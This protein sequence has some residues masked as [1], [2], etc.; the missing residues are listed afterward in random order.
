MIPYFDKGVP[1]TIAKWDMSWLCAN[2]PGGACEDLPRRVA[3]AR[4]REYNT[5]RIE[6]YP[7]QLPDAKTVFKKNCDP[8]AELPAWGHVGQTHECNLLERLSHLA[9]LCRANDIWLGL[10]TWFN[11]PKSP[12]GKIIEPDEEEQVFTE[13]SAMWVRALHLLREEGV[14]ERAVWV[15]PLNEVPHVFPGM[16]RS[17]KDLTSQLGK[18]GPDE[19]IAEQINALLKKQNHWMGEAIAPDIAKDGIP[20]SFSALYCAEA[21][22][23]RLTDLY[24]VVDTHYMPDVHL[25]DDDKVLMERAGEGASEFS[26][27]SDME[28]YDLKIYSE[29]WE[30]ACRKHYGAMLARVRRTH[31]QA[32]D[33][34]TLPS[35]K[36]LVPIITE[37]FGP[38]F[39]P[40]TPEMSWDWYKRYNADAAR[41]IAPL[42]YAGATL[43]NFAEPNFTIWEDADWHRC[44]NLFLLNSVYP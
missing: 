5:F 8:A 44:A 24:D 15:A 35:G 14:L 6:V 42:P 20:L 43:S 12:S 32:L 27:F 18:G 26:L 3:E 25:D 29:V 23:R 4:E 22:D 11:G 13:F 21:Y 36:R 10:D 33:N 17:V 38:C 28:R 2:Y 9:D 31:E 1:L 39:F 40:D 41:T 16:V 37:S 7:R 34:L 30:M 19:E